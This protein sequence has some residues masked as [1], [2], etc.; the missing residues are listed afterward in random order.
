MTS[1]ILAKNQTIN[2]SK[3]NPSLTKVKVGLRWGESNTRIPIDIDA[4]V[5]CNHF[6]NGDSKLLADSYFVFYNN[7]T[8]P[9][10][11]VI[12]SGDDTTGGGNSDNEVI[13]IDLNM[14]NPR[15]NEIAVW[16]NIHEAK[17]RRQTFGQ[18]P[19]V[20]LLIYDQSTNSTIVDYPVES[21]FVNETCLQVGSLIRQHGSWSFKAIGAG[22]T[23]ELID[24]VRGYGG[25]V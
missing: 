18:V 9:D 15:V 8:S 19:Y 25:N 16:I 20:S 6:A 13:E 23:M 11:A 4:M 10:G 17:T 5:F 12:H 14:V 22:Y 24:V 21:T 1:I 7:P 2:L 3:S